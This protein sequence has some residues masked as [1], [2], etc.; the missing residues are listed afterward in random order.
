MKNLIKFEKA[1]KRSQVF[2]ASAFILFLI[3]TCTQLGIFI[4]AT[5]NIQSLSCSLGFWFFNLGYTLFG[6]FTGNEALT[7]FYILIG[8]FNMGIK[9]YYFLSYGFGTLAIL[10]KISLIIY[11]SIRG[12]YHM[13]E[14]YISSPLK[15]GIYVAFSLESFLAFLTMIML[16]RFTT[17]SR[18]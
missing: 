15:I 5:I 8:L 16:G 7:L 4:A 1:S 11:L 18:V 17:Q 9:K 14:C 10:C 2:T 13:G 6:L 12:A 3:Y